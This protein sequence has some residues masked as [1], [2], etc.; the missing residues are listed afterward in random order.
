M[1]R[2]AGIFIPYANLMQTWQENLLQK[3]KKEEA[4]AAVLKSD[5]LIPDTN[6]PYGIPSRVE[7]H[8]Q[9]SLSL[10]EAAYECW[11]YRPGKKDQ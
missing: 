5:Q 8:N 9:A 7:L 4:K 3:E 6:V 11:R 10:M 1:K 2:I